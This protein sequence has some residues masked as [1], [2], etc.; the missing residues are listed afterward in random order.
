LSIGAA[1]RGLFVLINSVCPS[2]AERATCIAAI[3][4]LAPGLSSTTTLCLSALPSGSAMI[5]VTTSVPLPA[6][7]GT[8]MVIGLVGN[9][10]FASLQA[11]RATASMIQRFMSG[12]LPCLAS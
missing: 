3:A 7:N 5:R 12:F 9:S 4:P 10:A 6:P 1:E 2:G 8:T 11:T